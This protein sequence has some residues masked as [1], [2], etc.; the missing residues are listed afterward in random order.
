MSGSLA[1]KLIFWRKTSFEC[2]LMVLIRH[3][4]NCPGLSSSSWLM[5]F[6]KVWLLNLNSIEIYGSRICQI[7]NV[8]FPFWL[9]YKKK[10]NGGKG[11]PIWWEEK[12]PLMSNVSVGP[13]CLMFARWTLVLLELLSGPHVKCIAMCVSAPGRRRLKMSW[14]G[15]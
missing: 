10:E 3:E 8:N 13:P 5:N 14:A 4:L 15:Q 6:K 1:L 12:N 11:V 9:L 7:K 2:S